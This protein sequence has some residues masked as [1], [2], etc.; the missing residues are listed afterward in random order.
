[1][2]MRQVWPI[3]SIWEI[4]CRQLRIITFWNDCNI[5]VVWKSDTARATC[6]N[7]YIVRNLLFN[8][9]NS[10]GIKCL[11]LPLNPSIIQSYTANHSKNTSI[12]KNFWQSYTANHSKIL[13]NFNTFD[14]TNGFVTKWHQ[15]ILL[16]AI[17]QVHSFT[18]I[19]KEINNS[20]I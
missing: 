4:S 13:Q 15:L 9:T 16:N 8:F 17:K 1:M 10:F 20:Q 5:M 11:I 7:L 6:C 3:V 2:E 19:D 12:F 14:N 18:Y